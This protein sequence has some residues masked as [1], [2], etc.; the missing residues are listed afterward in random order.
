MKSWVCTG[1][2]DEAADEIDLAVF[3]LAAHEEV[4]LHQPACGVSPPAGET[5]ALRLSDAYRDTTS[6]ACAPLL[7]AREE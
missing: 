5:I 6:N 4:V 1:E 2:R 3:A 7:L